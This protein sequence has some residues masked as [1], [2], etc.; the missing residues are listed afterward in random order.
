MSPCWEER[1]GKWQDGWQACLSNGSQG[2]GDPA[3]TESWQGLTRE[4]AHI[5]AQSRGH[6]R[7]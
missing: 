6:G 1:G 7:Y 5:R 4:G 3:C 2:T